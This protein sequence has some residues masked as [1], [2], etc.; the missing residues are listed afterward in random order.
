METAMGTESDAVAFLAALAEAPHRYDFYQTLRRL[1]CL[2]RDKPRWGSAA[3]P[4]DE[5]IRLGQDPDLTFAPAALA[6]FNPGAD[7]QPG[8]LQVRV[9]GLMGPNGPLPLYLTEYVRERLRNANDPTLSRFLDVLQH[10][11]VA[12]FYRAWAQAQPH[13]SHDRPEDD[14]FASWVAALIGFGSKAL[15]GRD[16]VPDLG[17]FYHSGRLVHQTRPAEGLVAIV[18][19]FFRVPAQVERFVGQWLTLDVPERSSLARVGT[20]L[21]GGAVLGESVWDCQSRFRLRLGPLSYAQ[22]ESFL[23]GGSRLRQLIDWVRLYV[24]VE[25][26]WDLQL[27]LLAQEV[28]SAHLGGGERLGW[29]TWLGARGQPDDAE[30]LCLV[31]EA[32]VSVRVATWT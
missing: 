5:P 24:N 9:F 26:D 10:R 13:V 19:D 2:H 11:F 12:L 20:V 3:R 8:R 1:E 21:G 16:T 6:S 29:S 31:A 7:G 32:H 22:Y 28:P 30:D 23:P 27:R 18:R 14:R 4:L 25:L 15:R 17:K